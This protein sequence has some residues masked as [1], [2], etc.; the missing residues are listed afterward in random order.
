M[1]RLIRRI[2][3]PESWSE[4]DRFSPIPAGERVLETFRAAGFAD[5]T[6]SYAPGV[7]PELL[8][9]ARI[10][11]LGLGWDG[12]TP[13][14]CLNPAG[15]WKTRNWPLENYIRL[16]GDWLLRENV[17]F[18]LIGTDR[19]SSES[20]QLAGSMSAPILNLVGKTTLDEA[21]AVIQH[22]SAMVS[23]DSGLM[24]MAWVSGVPTVAIFGSSRYD[25]A[26]P[27]GPHSSLLHSGDL[28]CGAC[29]SPICARGDL[30]CLN[31]VTPESVLKL[32]LSLGSSSGVRRSAGTSP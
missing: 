14:V 11:L 5:L 8:E 24:H 31:R 19:I 30:Y 16:A 9:K 4:F 29:M 2:C 10:R 22:L 20:S 6:P 21:F 27:L 3:V 15:L 32:A 13:L 18:V 7:R 28:E 17:M 23:E 25:W 12:T 26:A 1:T